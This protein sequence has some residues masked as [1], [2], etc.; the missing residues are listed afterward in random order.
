MLRSQILLSSWLIN[1]KRTDS[2][3]T[4]NMISSSINTYNKQ[5]V[6]L[7]L[8]L[9]TVQLGMDYGIANKHGKPSKEKAVNIIQAAWQNGINT[10]DTAQVYGD[11]ETILGYAFKQIGINQDVKV[12]SKLSAKVDPLSTETIRQSVKKSIDNLG[13]SSLHGLLL[14][15]AAWLTYWEQGLGDCLLNLVREGLVSRI[16]VSVYT[17]EDAL[18]SLNY[19]KISTIQLPFNLFDQK[20]S[21]E[22]F[23]S[24]AQRKKCDVHVR[25][26]F[27]QGL[28][29]MD[30]E[31][32]PS[33]LF[34]IKPYLV[35]LEALCKEVKLSKK[36]L[37]LAY[38]YYRSGRNPLVIGAE[39]AEQV[40]ENS[41]LLRQVVAL[42]ESDLANLVSI[43]EDSLW[44]QDTTIINPAMWGAPA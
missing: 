36:F 9:G 25:S 1:R 19:R 29:L 34:D 17:V 28:L 23:F 7:P 44:I 24:L 13:V 27:L 38:A 40:L 37:A 21:R 30:S 32:V 16:G 22:D 4:K 15:D 26:V 11:S 18:N 12:I 3:I 33:Y 35:K 39:T 20:A 10:F 8:I 14:H 43:V 41:S 6:P 31:Q 2:N 42:E 5:E